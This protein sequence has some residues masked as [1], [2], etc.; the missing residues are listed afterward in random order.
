MSMSE[1]AWFQHLLGG[2]ESILSGMKAFTTSS[3]RSRLCCGALSDFDRFSP[4][5]DHR[6]GSSS[7]EDHVMN[8][9]LS[10]ATYVVHPVTEG[11]EV[12]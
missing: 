5:V 1:I 9:G 10:R 12:L 8:I 6:V 11:I 7:S 4:R 2:I 3:D